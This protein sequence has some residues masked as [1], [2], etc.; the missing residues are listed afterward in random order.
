MALA[1]ILL[2]Q[3]VVMFLL[4]SIGYGLFK[5]K[6]ITLQGNKEL[7]ILLIYVI[8][9]SSIMKSYITDYSQEKLYGLILSF[10]AAIA[11]LAVSVLI[12]R[13][14]FGNRQKVEHFGTA[15]SNAGF[16]GIP[17]VKAIVGEPAVFYVA[18]FVA[19][20]NIL[21]WTY[22]VVVMSGS[23]EAISLKKIATNP[24]IISLGIGLFLFISQIA[25]PSILTDSLAILGNMT[26]PVAMIT[27]GVYLAQI[28][29]WELFQE[30]WAYL[31]TLLRLIIIPVI[32]LGLL[33]LLP[34]Q[35]R[36]IKLTIL[37]AAAAPVGSNV[38]IFAQL[39]GLDYT[40]AVKSICLSTLFCIVTMPILIGVAGF[41]WK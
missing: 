6:K 33:T 21:Q 4:M 20:L 2:K 40:R 24:V 13:F 32:T 39:N 5:S 3:I 17:L 38:A 25:V 36:D 37:I 15:F 19:L 23:R 29:L 8:L 27:L 12:S 30:K 35:Y 41:L 22:G 26:A 18:A 14:V 10:L 34:G 1:F 9:P 7:G 31:S 11:A 28:Q 16:L